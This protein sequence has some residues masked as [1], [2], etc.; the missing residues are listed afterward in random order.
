MNVFIVENNVITNAI[1][2]DESNYEFMAGIIAQMF[3]AWV[4]VKETDAVKVNDGNPYGV[5]IG[6]HRNTNGEFFDPNWVAP[7]EP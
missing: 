1:S 6:W 7:Q 2:I 4:L 3:P 5:W